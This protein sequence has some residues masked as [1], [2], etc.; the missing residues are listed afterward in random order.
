MLTIG[1]VN[2]KFLLLGCVTLLSGC[3][4]NSRSHGKEKETLLIQVISNSKSVESIISESGKIINDIIKKELSL[5]QNDDFNFFLPKELQRITIYYLNEF[6]KSEEPVLFSS[7][8]DISLIAMLP[9]HIFA[10]ADLQFFGDQQDELVFIVDD[11]NK[12]LKNINLKIQKEL[13][14]LNDQYIKKEKTPLYSVQKSEKFPFLPHMGL[15]RI[16]L[17]SIKDRIKYIA[18]ETSTKNIID[19]IKKEIKEQISELVKKNLSKE[20]ELVVNKISILRLNPSSKKHEY[21]KEWTK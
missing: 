12:E 15:G 7:L 9:K 3:I 13:N 17:Q 14:K 11:R 20:S 19:R 21:I 16:R 4:F 6:N 10:T 18:D 8:D 1:S 5:D 2:K